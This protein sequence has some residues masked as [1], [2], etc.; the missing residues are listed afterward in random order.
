[1]LIITTIVSL[2]AN[3]LWFVTKVTE[4]SFSGSQFCLTVWESCALFK[5][6][7][8]DVNVCATVRTKSTYKVKRI[9]IDPR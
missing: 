3:V 7:A 5:G 6:P 9:R 1:M 8:R 2:S 4:C